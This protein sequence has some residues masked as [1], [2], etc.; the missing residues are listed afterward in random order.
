MG[1]DFEFKIKFLQAEDQ[2]KEYDFVCD[3]GDLLYDVSIKIC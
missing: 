2:T 1:G 3:L